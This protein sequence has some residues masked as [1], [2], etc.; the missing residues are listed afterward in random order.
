MESALNTAD[1][2]S[3]Q[4]CFTKI[5]M[6]PDF[7]KE[8]VDSWLQVDSYENNVDPESSEVKK[9]KMNTN[10]VK[11][12][13]D[14]LKR[15]QRFSSLR[16]VKVAVAFCLRYKRKLRET[17]LATRKALSDGVTAK[18]QLMVPQ[19]AQDSVLPIWKK[20]K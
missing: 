10:T 7:L 9:V 6:G 3:M 2:G 20:Q 5:Q 14:M 1:E 16:K 15:L 11:E 17:F 18:S 19:Q 12:S 4:G 13:S 8:P